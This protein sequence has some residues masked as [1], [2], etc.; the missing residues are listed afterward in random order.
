MVLPA[1][2]PVTIP[3]ASTVATEVFPEEYVTYVDSVTSRTLPSEKVPKSTSG[4]CSPSALKER[5]GICGLIAVGIS[6]RSTSTK[7]VADRAACPDVIA[8]I[9]VTMNFPHAML[10]GMLIESVAGTDV[11][12]LPNPMGSSPMTP[13]CE[14]EALAG[15]VTTTESACPGLTIVLSAG[16]VICRRG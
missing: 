5:L 15:D 6:T 4:N 2:P 9:A 10:A 12:V 16:E 1:L 13:T 7:I 3:F 11:E 8:P 14:N